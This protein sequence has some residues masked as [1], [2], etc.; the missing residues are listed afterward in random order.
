MPARPNYEKARQVIVDADEA[1]TA[2]LG[3]GLEG[4]LRICAP[5]TFA[6]L[7]IA[8][9]LRSFLDQH[10]KFRLELVMDDRPVDLA[11]ENIDVA[12]RLGELADLVLTARKIAQAERLVVA[13]PVAGRRAHPT[14]CWRMMR[15][16]APKIR[17]PNNGVFGGIGQGRMERGS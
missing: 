14:S 3:L 17:A 6:P 4:R 15:S 9:K 10:A 11:E 8:P 5:V 12:M 7:H 16:Y 2:A 13:S 1:E